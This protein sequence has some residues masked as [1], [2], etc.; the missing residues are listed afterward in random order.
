MF[1]FLPFYP[2]SIVFSL[3]WGPLAKSVLGYTLLFCGFLCVTLL[4]FFVVS[5]LHLKLNLDHFFVLYGFLSSLCAHHKCQCN[6]FSGRSL[7]PKPLINQGRYRF[8][9]R[10]QPIFSF[11]TYNFGYF[12]LLI[13]DQTDN[14]NIC[15]YISCA[16]NQLR[17]SQQLPN[18]VLFFLGTVPDFV[19]NALILS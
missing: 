14:V 10:F 17:S 1:S 18:A 8:R 15:T 13:F 12:D 11:N 7:G 6:F 5:W 2:F 19:S 4:I 9:G 3:F 16:K